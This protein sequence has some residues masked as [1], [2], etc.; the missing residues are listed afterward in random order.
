MEGLNADFIHMTL[1][2]GER[3]KRLNAIAIRQMQT[4]TVASQRLLT[5]DISTHIVPQRLMVMNFQ[6][7]YDFRT[8]LQDWDKTNAAR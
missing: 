4:L 6:F 3:L 7:R 1:P 5:Q 2:Q 8:S